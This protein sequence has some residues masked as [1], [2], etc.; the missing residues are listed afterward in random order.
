MNLYLSSY[1]VTTKFG[2]WV[3]NL[4]R[5]MVFRRFCPI[6]YGHI[7]QKYAGAEVVCCGLG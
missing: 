6:K 5:F 1:H 3:S 4:E 7:F 2:L